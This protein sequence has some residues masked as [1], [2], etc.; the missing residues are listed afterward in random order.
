MHSKSLIE[1]RQERSV[2]MIFPII[3]RFPEETLPKL[4]QPALI[5]EAGEELNLLS[6]HI[7]DFIAQNQD[8]TVIFIIIFI[9]II[10][11]SMLV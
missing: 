7:G 8:M 2:S 11:I 10:V 9:I 1:Y 5:E 6:E 3:P 4:I